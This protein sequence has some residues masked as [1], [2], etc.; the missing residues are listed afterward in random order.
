MV[1][2]KVSVLRGSLSV[3]IF[4]G[5]R[6]VT[7]LSLLGC[8]I[9]TFLS[10]LRNRQSAA[11]VGRGLKRESLDEGA[12]TRRPWTVDLVGWLAVLKSLEIGIVAPQSVRL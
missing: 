6:Q 8:V 7:H 5:F 11:R 1:R 4:T 3:N 12:N 10:K 9:G 2:P